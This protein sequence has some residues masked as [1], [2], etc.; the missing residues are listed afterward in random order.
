MLQNI[1]TSMSIKC[2]N[3]IL[4]P[5]SP[6]DT[7]TYCIQDADRVVGEAEAALFDAQARQQ[8]LHRLKDGVMDVLL[9]ALPSLK[10]AD[11]DGK[12]FAL[13]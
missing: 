5:C 7:L 1:R 13:P 6:I 8:L 4:P 3:R 10:L 12:W 9:A 2:C 11:V